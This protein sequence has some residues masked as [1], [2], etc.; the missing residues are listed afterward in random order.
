MA[1]GTSPF[2]ER[3]RRGRLGGAEKA[4]LLLMSIGEERASRILRHMDPTEVQRIGGAMAEIRDL[5][6]EVSAAILAEFLIHSGESAPLTAAGAGREGYIGVASV[7]AWGMEKGGALLDGLQIGSGK[8]LDALKWTDP[9]SIAELVRQEHPQ[10]VAL[11]LSSIEPAQ[12]ALV[13][14]ELPEAQ[15]ADILLRVATVG[16][17]QAA[18]LDELNEMLERQLQGETAVQATP[19]GGIKG[20]ARILNHLDDPYAVRIMERVR[21]VDA[22]LAQQIEDLLFVFEEL[23][24]V[25][26]R[27]IQLL[28]RQIPADTLVVALKGA[29]ERIKEKFF[30]NMTTRAAERLREDMAAKGPVRLSQVEACQK[31]VLAV[32]RR[33]A[34]EGQIHL[35]LGKERI[36][37]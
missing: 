14:Q 7:D 10:M 35:G 6:P 25:D 26:D 31:E 34:D 5:P 32:A 11:V 36:V 27:G 13:L 24:Q 17:V 30:G 15:R 3:Q 2:V 16:G 22:N 21:D 29:E 8:G 19:L 1:A 18:A 9:R 33:L 12:A 37:A 28:L 23:I 4:A 20:A